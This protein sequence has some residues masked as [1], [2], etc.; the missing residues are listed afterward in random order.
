MAIKYDSM[1]R[2]IDPNERVDYFG[3]DLLAQG[4][5]LV[6]PETIGLSELE[7]VN[8]AATAAAVAVAPRFALTKV[9]DETVN[10]NSSLVLTDA[11]LAPAGSTVDSVVAVDQRFTYT[12]ISGYVQP[13]SP[14]LLNVRFVAHNIQTTNETISNGTV[15][16]YV[17][18][19]GT[20]TVQPEMPNAL[21]TV[22]PGWRWLDINGVPKK[23]PIDAIG[24]NKT[25]FPTITIPAHSMT[26]IE[27]NSN[28]LRKV[29]ASLTGTRGS[30]TVGMDTSVPPGARVSLGTIAITAPT[31]RI[32]RASQPTAY[33]AGPIFTARVTSTDVVTVFA[34]NDAY[35]TFTV[36]AGT[37]I[38]VMTY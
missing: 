12:F 34:M 9:G 3:L 38:N 25:A 19:N 15:I 26:A 20:P 8:L 7:P 16:D 22:T 28:D 37:I 27:L 2:F 21:L 33:S 14:D 36:T 13:T 29:G 17:V 5:A 10:A 24:L 4:T 23:I 6:E 32:A 35:V 30:L 31:S 18:H 11:P 1:K